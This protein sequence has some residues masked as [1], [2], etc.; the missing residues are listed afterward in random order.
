MGDSTTNTTTRRTYPSL[1]A[2]TPSKMMVSRKSPP[3]TVAKT[4]R[5]SSHRARIDRNQTHEGAV[6]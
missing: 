5:Q 2:L 4:P 3:D 6:S 1:V